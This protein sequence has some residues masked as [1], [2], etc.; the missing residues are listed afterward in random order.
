MD[1]K[2][3]LF[4][5]AV[6]A[7]LCGGVLRQGAAAASRA[8]LMMYDFEKGLDRKLVTVNWDATFSLTDADGGKALRVATGHKADWPGITMRAPAGKWDL[9]SYRAVKLSVRNAG[10]GRA[11]VCLRVDNPGAD[12]AKNC[13]TGHLDLAPGQSETLTV[14][15]TSAPFRLDPPV[16]I[17]G[18]RGTPGSIGP[19]DPANVTQVL[20]FAPRPKADQLFVIDDL[21]AVGRVETRASRTFLPFIDEFG[22]YVHADWPGKLHS[23]D[24]FK[25]RIA[26]EEADLAKRPGPAG[27]GRYGG[28]QGGP[29]LKATG[30][31]YPARHGGK[32]WLVD[33]EGRLF[34]SHGPDCVHPNNATTPITDRKGYFRGLPEKGSPLAVFYGRGSWGPHGYYKGK[35]Y[36]SFNFTAANLRRKWGN[37]WKAKHAELAHRRL[38]S[39]G[40]N[41]VANWS[42]SG[43]YL[44]R[45][46]PYVVSIHFGGP[47][48]EGSEG[49]WGK[50]PDV[51]HDGFRGGLRR[52]LAGEKGKSAGDP[53]CIGY[54]VG[55]ELS[56]GNE[57]SLGVAALVSP[58]D[59]PAKKAFLADLKATYAT[60]DKLNA[61]WGTKHASWQALADSRTAPNRSRATADLHRFYSAAAEAYFRVCRE[62]CKRAAPKNLYLGCRFAWVN[63]RAARAAAKF[64]DVVSYN[65]YRYSVADFRL[66]AGL[67]MPVIIGEF[68]FGA[69]DRGMFHTGLRRTND[70]DDRA[71]KYRQY[72]RGALSNPQLV[73]AHW[74]QYGD[75]ATTGR[76]DGE[77]Y[78]IG[79]VNVVDT[80]Y[81]ETVA[82]VR[83]V[84]YAMYEHRAKAK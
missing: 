73:G 77:N 9:S 80:P 49:Y 74:F 35:R 4:A 61:A 1:G 19:L 28:W 54:F 39:W 38:R 26:A 70:Q 50:F 72:V 20:V 12:G 78:Q 24:E 57:D 83:D 52:R 44:Q 11:T 46:T 81:P 6:V 16:K 59:Q 23:T 14:P 34:W 45:K 21:R 51:F 68:H 3:S 67:D 8:P 40:M 5:F 66:P 71:D 64:C 13:L 15:L 27:W 48:I 17:I 75:Q 63:D 25:Q 69:L 41:T 65:F 7:L 22:Q 18:M 33:P 79:L 56:W 32:W 82:A 36:E 2:T 37:G 76:G 60:I 55:N 29:K 53:W 31:F 84:G 47:T 30:F 10:T 43:I 42:D 58:P 62:E